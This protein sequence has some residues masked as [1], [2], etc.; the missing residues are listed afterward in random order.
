MGDG[1][2]MEAELAEGRGRS[3]ALELACRGGGGVAADGGYY[4]NTGVLAVLPWLKEGLPAY[5]D[6]VPN[7]KVVIVQLEAFGESPDRR[8]GR[9][10]GWIMDTIGTLMTLMNVR[11]SSQDFRAEV[12]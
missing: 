8:V 6:Q 5:R 4:D 11:T 10:T 2:R 3:P 1:A 12:E 9:R 7:G